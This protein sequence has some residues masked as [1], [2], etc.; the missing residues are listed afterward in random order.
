VTEIIAKERNVSAQHVGYYRTR[1]PVKPITLE[2]IAAHPVTE[3][4]IKAV[5]RDLPP[6]LTGG[7]E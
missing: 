4:S 5:V 6:G 1:I 2:E 7:E 3:E